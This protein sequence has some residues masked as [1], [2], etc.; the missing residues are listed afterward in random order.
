MHTR[1]ALSDSELFSLKRFLAFGVKSHAARKHR[2]GRRCFYAISE[3]RL[4]SRKKVPLGAWLKPTRPSYTR[5]W[6]SE[7]CN[8]PERTDFGSGLR[9]KQAANPKSKKRPMADETDRPLEWPIQPQDWPPRRRKKGHPGHR[10][11][12]PAQKKRTA[13]TRREPTDDTAGGVILQ[14]NELLRGTARRVRKKNE[15]QE[16][17]TWREAGGLLLNMH[18]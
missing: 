7:G 11:G 16:R 18:F 17:A 6:S 15:L 3:I 14:K 8:A 5:V 13:H 4:T 1:S 10:S 9:Q 12:H 2:F